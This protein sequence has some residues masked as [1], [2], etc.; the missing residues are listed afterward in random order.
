MKLRL[1]AQTKIKGLKGYTLP[2]HFEKK[3]PP[4]V[5]KVCS[6]C[7]LHTPQGSQ[8]TSV[9]FFFTIITVCLINIFT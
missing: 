4:D 7:R 6:I 2:V 9:V 5:A 1:R 8:S 3:K